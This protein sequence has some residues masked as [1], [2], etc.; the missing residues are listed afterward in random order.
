MKL[1]DKNSLQSILGEFT[2]LG[3]NSAEL[4]CIA[5]YMESDVEDESLLSAIKMRD[6]SSLNY[7]KTKLRSIQDK[8]SKNENTE[9]YKRFLK[10]IFAFAG[11]TCAHVIL[12]YSSYMGQIKE[13]LPS[14]QYI[15]LYAESMAFNKYDL[16]ERYI[17]ELKNDCMQNPEEAIKAIEYCISDMANAETLV[18]GFAYN[19]LLSKKIGETKGENI[20]F[21]ANED[22]EQIFDFFED[23]EFYYD[24]SHANYVQNIVDSMINMFSAVNSA[25]ERTVM[26]FVANYDDKAEIPHE[27]KDICNQSQINELLAYL[28]CGTAAL[29]MQF[30]ARLRGF[31]RLCMCADVKLVSQAILETNNSDRDRIFT[32][33]EKFAVSDFIQYFAWCGEARYDEPI[34][35]LYNSKKAEYED[36]LKEVETIEAYNVLVSAIKDIDLKR[37]DELKGDPQELK[38]KI[39]NSVANDAEFARVEVFEYIMGQYSLQELM[40]KVDFTCFN[41]GNSYGTNRQLDR[42]TKLNGV[43][44][45]V[46]RS[47]I[48]YV[49]IGKSHPITTLLERKQG[50]AH[51][52]Y[53][54][55]SVTK[56]FDMFNEEGLPLEYQ[57]KA[58]DYI[59]SWV[60]T[61]DCKNSIAQIAAKSMVKKI[62]EDDELFYAT[63]KGASAYVR[64]IAMIAYGI[65]P[66]K[67]KDRILSFTGDG[68]GAVR[69]V[70]LDIISKQHDWE[71]DVLNLL[72][73]KKSAHREIAVKVINLWGAGKYKDILTAALDKEKSKGL[74][75]LI[76]NALG[77]SGDSHSKDSAPQS[78]QQ[79]A[80]RLLKGGKI[81]SIQWL[82]EL[83][84][85]K[86]ADGTTADPNYVAAVML[87]YASMPIPGVSAEAGAIA[88]TLEASSLSLYATDVFQ[89]WLDD[90]A[91]AKKKWV[92]Y[93]ASIHGG[94]NVAQSL[95]SHINKWPQESRGAIAAEA[96]KALALNSAPEALL[97]VDTISRKFK[98]KQ[99]KSAATDALKFAAEQLGISTEELADRIVPDL[100]FDENMQKVIDYGTRK[101][102][103]R[104]NPALEVEV[105]DQNGKRLKNLPSP[106]QKDDQVLA[107]QANNEFKALKKSIKA[108]VNTQ[109]IR[110]ELALSTGRKWTSEVWT[111]LFVQNPIM[112]QFAMSLIWG[113]YSDNSL[114]QTFRYMEDGTFNTEDEEEYDV[115][116]SAIIGLVHP[117]ELTSDSIS[118]WKQQLED[119]EV[120]Q[121][122]EQLDRPTY[123]P[124]EEE[125]KC[126]RVLV[127]AGKI[128]S[129]M[130]LLG[131]MTTL[132]WYKGVPQDAGVFYE[133]Y[134]E[135]V[136]DGV[137]VQ[138]DFAGMY[139]GGYDDEEVTVF[140]AVFYKNNAKIYDKI[141]PEDV[142][143]I[144]DLPVS[145]YSEI[146]LQISRATASSSE[147][148]ENWRKEKY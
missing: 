34:K 8:L 109:K 26:E 43:D 142:V 117:L 33:L 82:G 20:S 17:S 13:L 80:E 146:A 29:N 97:T 110:M 99:V 102:T 144:S 140:D 148:N 9:E 137:S 90:G 114:I 139:V 23:K 119:Y 36:A 115:P 1:R 48:V 133:F 40:Q 10:A 51:L 104:L 136:A 93:F 35:R 83:P 47:H 71:S 98:F 118:V 92:L 64:K 31:L 143:K 18:S 86:M 122:I 63:L 84:E 74:I 88:S 6:I 14:A 147:T 61:D 95:I 108:T 38:R 69:E 129:S 39:A 58:I 73:A 94:T 111:K 44:E 77:N 19:A 78:A 2:A 72:N 54:D 46:R 57:F 96:V 85:V 121:C 91:Q 112:H 68:S 113:V 37:Y 116:K 145:V 66:E 123:M 22:R 105:F 42:Y 24:H 89:R 103:V 11:S 70:I 30:S 41:G 32:E 79:I 100:G 55:E 76:N 130:S 59:Y 52:I 132:G 126:D 65:N 135:N 60:F 67:Y 128:L 45:I 53:T 134:R 25:N 125:L 12:T 56:I 138:L 101:F 7:D 127:G 3:A 131:K 107:P 141:K 28:L 87:A 5:K 75:D 120:K 106:G 16:Y 62:E 21:F 81:R 124:S 50:D 4:D 27:V 15:A 49:L